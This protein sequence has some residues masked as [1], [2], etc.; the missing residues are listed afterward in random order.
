MVGKRGFAAFVIA[1]CISN[2]SLLADNDGWVIRQITNRGYIGPSYGI[3]GPDMAVSGRN[4]VWIEL[5]KRLMFFDGDS[6]KQITDGTE[7]VYSPQISGNNVVWMQQADNGFKIMFW[8]GANVKQISN[9][10]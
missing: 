6:T 2:G 10:R 3:D 1:I 9:G 7:Y 4:I 8:D 5:N